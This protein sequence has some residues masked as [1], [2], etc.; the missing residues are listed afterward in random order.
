MEALA[1]QSVSG[2]LTS[3]AGVFSISELNMQEKQ[4]LEMALRPYAPSEE[5]IVDDLPLLFTLASEV[6]AIHNQAALLHGER[7]KRVQQILTNYRDGA[8]SAWLIAVYGNRQTPYN[9]LQ[10]Y[11]FC[12]AMPK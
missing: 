12:E 8:F 7:I 9:F 6:R 10:Y 2:H 5:T 11:E 1:R 3:F 4:A